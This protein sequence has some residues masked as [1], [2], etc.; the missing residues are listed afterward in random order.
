MLSFIFSDAATSLKAVWEFQI[1]KLWASW[2]PS[3][4]ECKVFCQS[5]SDTFSSKPKK[6]QS[7]LN[8]LWHI[9]FF[10]PLTGFLVFTNLLVL[11]WKIHHTC[12][13]GIDGVGGIMTETYIS[14]H[15]RKCHLA[16]SCIVSCPWPRTHFHPLKA[17]S[18][19]LSDTATG[20]QDQFWMVLARLQSQGEAQSPQLTP[21]LGC[22]LAGGRQ[23]RDSQPGAATLPLDFGSGTGPGSETLAWHHMGVNNCL[24]YIPFFMYNILSLL[25]TWN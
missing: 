19:C 2:V 8:C 17:V 12:K 3:F 25:P 22:A 9:S 15:Q 23:S 5:Y 13:F 24:Y 20:T 1:L 14:C 7:Q 6:S 18:P 16:A 21:D 11:L 10:L 4:W